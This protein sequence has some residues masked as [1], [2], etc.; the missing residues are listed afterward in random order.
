MAKIVFAKDPEKF[1]SALAG[2]L[3]KVPEFKVPEW[4]GFVKSG[5]SRE[6]PPVDDDFWYV[7]A[8][9]ILRQLYIKG[10]VGVGKLRT[11]YGSKKDRGGKASKFRKASGKIIRV[12]LQQAE[13]AGLVE[14]VSRLQYGRR[15]TQAGRDFLDSIEVGDEESSKIKSEEWTMASPAAVQMSGVRDQI[16]EEGDEVEETVE[17]K[18]EEVVADGK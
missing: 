11:R 17:D 2:A 3:K 14:K 8:A 12:I 9:S 6:R 13:A 18:V 5:V 7:R 1:V 15:L 4:V 16:S 10:V